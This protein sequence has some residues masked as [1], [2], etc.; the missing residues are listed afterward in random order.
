MADVFIS[1]SRKDREPVRKLIA[2]LNKQHISYWIDFKDIRKD[3][4]YDDQIPNAIQACKI[5]VMLISE[6]SLSSPHVKKELR[7]ADTFQKPFIL[8]MLEDVM[9][10]EAFV[11]HIDSCH[12][13]DASQDWDAAMTEFMASLESCAGIK[14]RSRETDLISA[15][16]VCPLCRYAD[17]AVYDD[18]LTRLKNNHICLS[19]AYNRLTLLAT[20]AIITGMTWFSAIGVHKVFSPDYALPAEEAL[21]LKLCF[22]AIYLVTALLVALCLLIQKLWEHRRRVRVRQ[23]IRIELC[24][25]QKCRH[26]FKAV[27]PVAPKQKKS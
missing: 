22:L 2:E 7:C 6:N 13:I 14:L 26:K 1:Y 24:R 3:T 9:L 11:Y 4:P 18:W 20:L 12:R 23:H 17:F 10:R 15:G 5:V 16:I 27:I 25:C 8:L 21:Q 19:F